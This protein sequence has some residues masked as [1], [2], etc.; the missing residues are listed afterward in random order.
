M[1]TSESPTLS[2]NRIPASGGIAIYRG[3]K[4]EEI[5]MSFFEKKKGVQLPTWMEV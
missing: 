3:G 2:H 1:V 5:E 4:L